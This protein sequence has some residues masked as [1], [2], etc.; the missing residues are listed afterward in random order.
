MLAVLAA[1]A[2][3]LWPSAALVLLGSGTRPTRSH[4][5]TN[6]PGT[7]CPVR[8]HMLGLLGPL[9]GQVLL[10]WGT[11]SAARY[12]SL[13]QQQQAGLLLVSGSAWVWHMASSNRG[14]TACL[15]GSTAVATAAGLAATPAV[16]GGRLVRATAWLG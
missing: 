7:G 2:W 9:G 14:S 10:S 3:V 8:Q 6:K 1:Q 11:G 12:S 15:G 5:R 13:W 16:L 4:S